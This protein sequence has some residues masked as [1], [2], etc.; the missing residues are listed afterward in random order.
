MKDRSLITE[1]ETRWGSTFNAVEHFI[2]LEPAIRKMLV[3]DYSLTHLLLPAE[4][5]EVLKDVLAALKPVSMLTD[6]LS[7]MSNKLHCFYSL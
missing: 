7:G 1:C 5:L 6:I 4:K 2:E 3:A